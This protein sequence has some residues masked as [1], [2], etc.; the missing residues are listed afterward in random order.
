MQEVAA[1]KRH[2][3]KG[4][5]KS[6]TKAMITCMT[7]VRSEVNYCSEPWTIINADEFCT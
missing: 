1:K 7:I 5:I 2:C 4:L 6:Q 3:A